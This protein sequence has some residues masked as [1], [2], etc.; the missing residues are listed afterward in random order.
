MITLYDYFIRLPKNIVEHLLKLATV[1]TLSRAT[2]LAGT[3]N[4][5]S[6][7]ERRVRRN[8]EQGSLGRGDRVGGCWASPGHGDCPVP[9]ST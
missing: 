3:C 8:G 2:R 9:K 1:Y 7:L 4:L 6:G 5:A